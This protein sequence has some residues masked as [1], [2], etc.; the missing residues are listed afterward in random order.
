M[1]AKRFEL[2]WVNLQTC[3]VMIGVRLS[4]V[5]L[6]TWAPVQ[7]EDFKNKPLVGYGGASYKSNLMCIRFDASMFVRG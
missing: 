7:G 1:L 5:G 6:P 4:H 2:Q 3:A